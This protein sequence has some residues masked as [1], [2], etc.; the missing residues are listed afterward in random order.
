[1][2]LVVGA[3][4]VGG[5]LAARMHLAGIDLTVVQR[6]PHGEAI[7]ERGLTVEAPDGTVTVPLRCLPRIETA[8]VAAV[9]VATKT[10]DVAAVAHDLAGFPG[11][12][13]CLTNGLEAERI[14]AR[15]GLD[16]HGVCV[17]APCEHL[18][19]GLVRQWTD[20]P[21]GILDCGRWPDGQ[22]SAAVFADAFRAAG[23]RSTPR[24]DIVRWKRTRL[25]LNLGNV[26]E[27]LGLDRALADQARAEARAVYDAAGLA[28]A[29]EAEDKELRAGLASKPIGATTRKG[30]STW[31]SRARGKPLETPY[32]N[33]EIVL[34]GRLHGV[35]TPANSQL[36]AA[37]ATASR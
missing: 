27:A 17:M 21:R 2:F 4:A 5:A 34:L 22:G 30:G 6:G 35:P 9:I 25:L 20:S 28:Y 3:G 31:Q 12:V 37:A 36:V 32:L 24:A 18:E 29:S 16:V 10:H 13:A 19:P 1:M 14:G 26:V 8:G 33:G 7:R 15:A 11:P 23:Y